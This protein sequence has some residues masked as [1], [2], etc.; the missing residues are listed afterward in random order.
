MLSPQIRIYIASAQMQREDWELGI[1][2]WLRRL[3]FRVLG[4]VPV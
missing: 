3:A 1:G 2:Y 4:F